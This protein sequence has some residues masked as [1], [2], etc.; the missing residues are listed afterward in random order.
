MVNMKLK[1]II[2]H[3]VASLL[4]ISMVGL[5][6]LSSFNKNIEIPTILIS[7]GSSAVG[8]YLSKGIKF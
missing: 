5:L 8:F 7:L 4:I 3:A 6:V 1:E 2:T